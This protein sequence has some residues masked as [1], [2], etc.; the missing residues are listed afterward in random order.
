MSIMRISSAGLKECVARLNEIG[1]AGQTDK[2]RAVL[3]AALEPIR[4]QAIQNIHS[5]SGRTAAAIVVAAGKSQ[6]PSAYVKVDR[7][8]A[9]A[10]WKGRPFSYPYA[11][12]YGHGGPH[13]APA[14]PFFGP[15][16]RSARA[17]VRSL[18]NDGAREMF[19]AYTS[20]VGIGSEFS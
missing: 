20:P 1:N 5:V 7:K 15:A 19:T 12:E 14:H 8:L 10:L 11:V 18:V 13:A 2:F 4:D 17:E 9:Q 3:V 6:N 16:F